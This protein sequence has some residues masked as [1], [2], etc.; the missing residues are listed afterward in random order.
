MNNEILNIETIEAT[1]F[2][3]ET[4]IVTLSECPTKEEMDFLFDNDESIILEF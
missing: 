3:V 2:N 4:T 1:D